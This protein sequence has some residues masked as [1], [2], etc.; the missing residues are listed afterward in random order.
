[1]QGMEFHALQILLLEL[2][3]MRPGGNH[4]PRRTPLL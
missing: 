3:G 1:M 2:T 4:P